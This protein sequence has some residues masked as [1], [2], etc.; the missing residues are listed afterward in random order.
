MQEVSPQKAKRHLVRTILIVLAILLLFAFAVQVTDIGLEKPLD[1][2]RQENV[3]RTLRLLADPDLV[4]V[5]AE[6]GSLGLS[7]A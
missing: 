2:V 4:K 6:T 1:P 5:D 3:L 7:D